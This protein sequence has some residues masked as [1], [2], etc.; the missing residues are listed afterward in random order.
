LFDIIRS[1]R[2]SGTRQLRPSDRP[3]PNLTSGPASQL[4]HV[5]ARLNVHACMH[6]G[7][8]VGWENPE[9]AVIV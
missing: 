4:D 3:R 5:R 9:P 6:V 2:G 7:M 8:K 1:D